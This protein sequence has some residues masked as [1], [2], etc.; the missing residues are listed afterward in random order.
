MRE[1]VEGLPCVYP[2]LEP[3]HAPKHLPEHERAQWRDA[4]FDC[5]EAC[6]LHHKHLWAKTTAD[7]VVKAMVDRRQNFSEVQQRTL[8]EWNA[9]VKG[10]F[11]M[12]QQARARPAIAR[13]AIA[14]R[15]VL[16][17]QRT[18]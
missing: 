1:A 3:K 9:T 13:P 18:T 8:Q 10:Q 2:A 16:A 5:A 7:M 4:I 17:A 12:R 15:A 11:I 14:R 6:M